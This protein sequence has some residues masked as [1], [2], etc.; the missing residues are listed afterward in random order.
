MSRWLLPLIA[1][2]GG[3]LVGAGA[4][5]G[6]QRTV[7][8]G[9]QVRDY[10]LEHPEVIPEAMQRLQDRESGQAVAAL[11][12]ALEKPVGSAWAGNPRGDVTVVEFFDYNCGYCRANLPTIAQL[13]ASDPKVR[14][15]YREFPILSEA[16]RTAA[17]ASLAA[18]R[19][20]KF[21]GFH[22][23]LY[24]AG[25]VSDAT[26][27]AAAQQ[28]GVS[29]ARLDT[30]ALDAEIAHNYAL[31]SKLGLSGTPSWVIGDRVLAG[32]QSLEKLRAAVTEARQR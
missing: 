17:R 11:R 30:A 13:V 19:Q 28:A 23:A 26:I 5:L 7:A 31:A 4:T 18:A 20:G 27:A 3:G 1:A 21:A 8:V 25:Q 16:S 10:L 15:V 9:P 14:V 22:D 6:L 32:A 24:A 12:P 2:L 29:L